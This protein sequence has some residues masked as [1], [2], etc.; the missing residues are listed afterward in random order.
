LAKAVNQEHVEFLAKNLQ[1]DQRL[2]YPN[3]NSGYGKGQGLAHC[4]EETP[5]VPISVYGITKC[6]A[7]K[8]V[9]DVGGT[10]FRLATVFGISP[11]MRLDLLVNDFVLRARRDK[12]LVL[13]EPHFKRNYIHVDDVVHAFTMMTYRSMG[14]EDHLV[15]GQAFNLG[16]SDAN[17]SKMELAEIIKKYVP[18]LNIFVAEFA[19][20]PDQ[21]NYIV[22][23]EKI[24]KL[25]FK[26]RFTLD[27]GVS[28]LL[29]YYPVF[30]RIV[31][32]GFTNL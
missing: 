32:A 31:N 9:L 19:K 24:E 16:L 10:T 15:R 28:E 23:N 12:F 18:D 13:F 11:R 6:E 26:P 5:L 17:L 30:D 29:Q 27:N 3:T 2:I 4:T 25:G 20:D 8:A 22:S 21:R 1:K 14:D 7:E